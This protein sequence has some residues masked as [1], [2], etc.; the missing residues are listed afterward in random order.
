MSDILEFILIFYQILLELTET[1]A[2]MSSGVFYKA[3]KLEQTLG[4]QEGKFK[5]S[6]KSMNKLN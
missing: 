2:V 3:S 5:S 1:P 6:A 4:T